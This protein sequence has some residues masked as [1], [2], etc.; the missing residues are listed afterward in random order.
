M[1]DTTPQRAHIRH[2]DGLAFM[3]CEPCAIER[4]CPTRAATRKAVDDHNHKKHK[5]RQA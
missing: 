3:V 2:T 1:T 4:I 5:E